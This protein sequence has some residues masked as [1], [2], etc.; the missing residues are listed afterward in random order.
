MKSLN[1]QPSGY[2]FTIFQIICIKSD[3]LY[4]YAPK[5]NISGYGFALASQILL[6]TRP[7]DLN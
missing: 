2:I 6:D 1:R 7:D 5:F 3:Y 4:K